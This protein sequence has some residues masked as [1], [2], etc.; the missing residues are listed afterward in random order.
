MGSTVIKTTKTVYPQIY[1]YVTP[2]YEPNNGWI[3]IGY[4]TRKDVDERIRQQT[5]TAGIHYD[6]LWFGPAKFYNSDDWFKDKELHSYL[7]KFRDIEQ[8]KASEWFYYDGYPEKAHEHYESFRRREWDQL[9]K[10]QE[11]TLR[12]EQ[13]KA[14]QMTLAYAA[15]NKTRR[16]F[17]WN[18]KP[19]FG[20]TLTAYDLAGR[21]EARNVLIVTN[22]PAIANSWFDDFTTFI[23]K[24]FNYRFVS[25]TDSL[26]E[27]N[28]LT[29]EEFVKNPYTS[30]GQLAG[31]MAFVSLQDLK[32]SLYFGGSYEKLKWVRDLEWDLLIIDEAHEGVDTLKT[33][34]AF[35]NITRDFT[36]HLSGTPFRAIASGKFSENQI[37]N[38]S[39]ADEQTAKAEWDVTSE[40]NNPY[41][42][43]PRLNM[44]SYQMSQ[45]I[46]DE[47]NKGAEIDGSNIDFAFD[48]NE[49]FETNNSGKFVHEAEVVKWL[50]TLTRN[51]K[52]PFSTPELRAELKHTFWLLE[53]VASAKALERL[54]RSHPVFENY[55]IVL[56]AGDGRRYEDEETVRERS[57]DRVREAIRENERTITL[58]VGQLTTGVTIPEWSGVVM[59]SNVKSAS[60]YMQAAFRA[61]NPW[62]YEADGVFQCKESAYVFDFAPERTLIIYDEFANN[63][64][65]K[66]AGG[67]GTTSDRE[68][69]IRVLLNFFPVIAEDGEGRM[70]ELDVNQVLTIPKAIKAQ[71]VVKRGFMS[72]LLFQNISGIF[73][74]EAKE[75]C[76]ILEQLKPVAPGRVTPSATSSPIDT[77]G[78]EVDEEGQA[79]VGHGLVVSTTNAK[80]GEKVYTTLAGVASQPAPNLTSTIATAFSREVTGIAKEIAKEQGVT[81][82]QAEIIVRQQ[83]NILA[84][85]VQVM[86][87]QSDI[88]TAEAEVTYKAE[89]EEAGRDDSA[90]AAAK[91]RFEVKQ[92]EIAVKLQEEL[93]ETVATKTREL[94]EGT[95]GA[96]LQRG[97]ER[98][99]VTVEDDIRSRLRGFA[100][101][102]PSFLMAYG[103][104]ETTLENFD[105]NIRDEVFQ[106]VT[107]ITLDQFR[108]LRDQ[109]NFFDAVVFNESVQEF[110]RKREELANYF[111]EDQS[112][113][114]FDYIPPQQTNQIFTPKRVVRMMIDALEEEN[115]D[116]FSEKDKTFVDLYVKS[117]LYLTE[118]VKRLYKGLEKQIPD[119][120][121]RLRHILENQV[122]GFAPTEIIHAIARNFIFGKFADIDNSNLRCHDLTSA[123]RGEE[124]IEMKFDVVVGNPPYQEESGGAG[125]QA[126]PIYQLF[127]KQAKKINPHLISLIIPSRWFSGGMGLDGFRDDMLNDSQ[128]VSITDF[129]NAKDCFPNNSISGGVCYFLRSRSFNGKCTFVNM[130][131]KKS[132]S[133]V[134]ELNEFPVMIRYNEAVH[135]LR[136]IRGIDNEAS[137]TELASS[138]TPF[139]L[140]TNFR[141]TE[142]KIKETDLTVQTSVG[143]SY[144]SKK[145]IEKGLGYIGKYKVLVS[146]TS[147]EHA[148]EPDK[149]GQFGVLTSS[150]RVMHPDEICTHSYFVMGKFDEVTSAE[151]L[152]SYLKTKMVRFLVLQS[153]TSI[154]VSKSVFQFVPLQDFT[155]ESDIDW[156]KTIPE[157]DQQL[158]AKYGLDE[159]EIA[160]IDEKVKEMG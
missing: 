5:Q 111:D 75:V 128:I 153:M 8:R 39:Y 140:P 11:Y 95:T 4:T 87:M 27:S 88:E 83:A 10:S 96:I 116:L 2:E 59:L 19:R 28:T 148:G 80:F 90:I 127:V 33:D 3:K 68:E 15:A 69:N 89:V 14:V 115:P 30:D 141:G 72:N 156:T 50:D 12:D 64:S 139:G 56:A 117:G 121:Q 132:N 44:F 114:I 26:K 49:F 118:I 94:V 48:L 18:A 84:R 149:N 25:T 40:E 58:S 106:E 78:V 102:I 77:Q 34:V 6:K 74:A 100:R 17:L 16:E 122:Y 125:R 91:A 22:R 86:Q 71:E 142:I 38:W 76:E 9:D 35:D 107:G 143:I 62:S 113:D 105:V 98:K 65:S 108:V 126:V 81:A 136:K 158:Y 92:Q 109:Y 20:K 73:A 133:M 47:V 93:A 32:G 53:R 123:A 13:E 159:K 37:F 104:L 51:E 146:K 119:S 112:E 157:I 43:L 60:L 130:S 79:V 45:M 70:V 131:G 1:A 103:E 154:N 41:E 120:D 85:E 134:R 54:L 135:I 124:E 129:P 147:A 29:R 150:V 155:P 145:K 63:L 23:E 138:L 61:Q 24:K 152:L 97:E 151:N 82:A 101:T 21:M 31:C 144:I 99:K 46:T 36:L 110:L 7:R 42:G 52:Y 57:F 67:G 137:I 55:E 160:F 66:T